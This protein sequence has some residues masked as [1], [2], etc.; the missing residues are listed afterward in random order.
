MKKT[1]VLVILG[2]FSTLA[3]FGN[4]LLTKDMLREVKAEPQ[5]ETKAPSDRPSVNNPQP[6]TQGE[7]LPPPPQLT[8]EQMTELT[9]EYPSKPH[10]QKIGL[11]CV[12]CHGN[13]ADKSEAKRLTNQE[14]LTCHKDYE[15]VRTRTGFLDKDRTNPHFGFHH[16]FELDCVECHREHKESRTYCS[17]CH[18]IEMWMQPAK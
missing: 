14:C 17:Y 11:T 7:Q 9:K 2:I 18:D 12:N 16:E 5:I 13:I 15:T 3:I 1:I 8:K 4:H 6:K 10:H